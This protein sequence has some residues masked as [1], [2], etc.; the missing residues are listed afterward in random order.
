[1]KGKQVLQEREGEAE[2]LSGGRDGEPKEGI[3]LG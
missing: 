2:G 1:V 3:S